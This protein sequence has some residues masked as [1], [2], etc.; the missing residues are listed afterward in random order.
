MTDLTRCPEELV[1]WRRRGVVT[2]RRHRHDQP[3][4]VT[5]PTLVASRL[6]APRLIAIAVIG[7]ALSGCG[8]H[9]LAP[10]IDARAGGTK[11]VPATHSV[12]RG[13]TVYAVAWRYGL[14]PERV[15]AVNGLPRPY[16]IYPGQRLRLQRARTPAAPAKRLESG[17]AIRPSEGVE[18]SPAVVRSERP[19]APATGSPAANPVASTPV[20]SPARPAPATPVP[21]KVAWRWPAS[22]RLIRRFGDR[23]S[24]GIEIAGT[25]NQPVTS[26][27]T[28]KV[29][30]SGS[31]L[32]GYG[33]LIIVKH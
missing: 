5:S 19:T 13:E 12:R 33:N 32:I 30:Y 27:A 3:R 26:A 21:A 29:V 22:G 11:G 31:G 17:G 25:K 28:G 6:I 7:A 14:D 4:F 16:V 20:R 23:G 15:I 24:K 2:C 10:V 1:A 9:A 8:S 18:R